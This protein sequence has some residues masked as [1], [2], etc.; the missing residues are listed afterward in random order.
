MKHYILLTLLILTTT[1]EATAQRCRVFGTVRDQ[2]GQPIELATVRISGTAIGTSCNLKGEYS[3]TFESR[4]TV[5]V[6]YSMIG[7][8]TR[9]RTLRAPR[10]SVRIDVMLPTYGTMLGEAVAVGQ[11]VQSGTIQKITPV[12]THTMPSTTGNGVEEIIATQAGVSTHNE[13]SSQYNV[14]GGSYDENVVYLN[15]VEIYRPMLIRSGQQE[16]LSIIN[17]DMVEN[18]GFSSGSF[19]ARYGDKMSSVLDITYKRPTAFEASA[20]AS[21]LGAGAYLGWGNKHFSAMT[22]VRYKTT[23][24]LLGALDTNGEYKPNFLDYQLVLSYRPSSRWS[25]D[26]LG[27]VSDNTYKF[28][29]ADRETNFGT[30]YDAKTFKVYFDGWEDDQYRTLFG[31]ATVTRHFSPQ[32]F[33]ALQLSAFNTKEAETYDIQGQ[34][35]LQEATSQEQLGVGTYLEHARNHL[36]ANVF[37]VGLRYR[38]KW[39][40]HTLQAGADWRRE[41]IRERAVEWEMRDS[42][43]YSLPHNPD[44]LRLI[45]SLRSDNRLNVDR[46]EAYVQDTWRHHGGSGLWNLTYGV[47]FS[48]NSWNQEPLIS[49]RASVGFVPERNDNW[50]FRFATGL[51]YQAPFYKE[52]RDTVLQQGT[53]QV[54]L[55][56]AVKSQRSIH[57]VLGADYTFRI[58]GRPFKFT[59]EAYYKHLSNL[60]PYT[61]DNMRVVYYPR[62]TSN[63]YAT[64]VD[65][66]IFGEFVPGADSWLTF[67]LMSTQEKLNGD[68]MPRPT[69]QRYNINFYFNDYFPGTTRWAFNLKAAIAGGLPF[70][71]PHS[72]GNKFRAPAY[73]RLDMGL[74]YKIIGSDEDAARRRGLTS[75]SSRQN[76]H[77]RSLWLGFDALNLIGIRNVN[78]YY[79]ITDITNTQ[80][81]VPNYLTGRQ[82]NVRLSIELR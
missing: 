44:E 70:G 8:E 60:I 41:A 28:I 38:N 47:R 82:F 78:S 53:A 20:Y 55:N 22:S 23:R 24:Y 25:F 71:T 49:P 59:A 64:G 39:G 65:F 26:F 57:F 45:Y 58:A 50:T 30:M 51:Y 77:I 2:D 5:T 27:N 72:L 31:S 67:S 11:G 21:I 80:Y 69:D 43:G 66:K 35:W 68:W 19:E 34:Y 61:V 75:R 79:W 46:F 63:G 36:T 52:L 9:K 33:L 13:L 4:D 12:D 37:D 1:M 10:D 16:G 54:F 29:P 48:Y 15:G 32:S 73:K 3:L 6:Q 74:S 17:S 7:Y 56:D 62:T 40:G 81:A 76:K 42:M 18:I 14:R